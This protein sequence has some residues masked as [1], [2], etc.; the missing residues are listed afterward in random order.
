MRA[1]KYVE[2]YISRWAASGQYKEVIYPKP[3]FLLAGL[4]H[5]GVTTST[6]QSFNFLSA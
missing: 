1:V 2:I 6:V 5:A 3:N 4:V